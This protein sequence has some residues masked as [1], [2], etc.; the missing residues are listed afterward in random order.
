VNWGHSLQGVDIV[1]SSEMRMQGW[2]V[3][4]VSWIE[5]GKGEVAIWVSLVS[6]SREPDGL[7]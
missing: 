7:A 3:E 6:A 2:N 4:D 5:R 1:D